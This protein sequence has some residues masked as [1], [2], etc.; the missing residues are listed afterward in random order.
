MIESLLIPKEDIT[1]IPESLNCRDALM[2]LE[3]TDQR[4]A[5]VVDASNS[6]F[7]GNIYKYHI[8][9]YAFHHPQEDLGQVSVTNLLKNSSRI[10]HIQD[11]LHTLL[12]T[13]RDL[14]YIP[15]LDQNHHFVGVVYHGDFTSYLSKA[16]EGQSPYVIRVE[17]SDIIRD[18]HRILKITHRY[19]TYSSLLTFK[20]TPLNPHPFVM[21]TLDKATDPIKIN[22]L[23][24]VLNRKGYLAKS[25]KT[26]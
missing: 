13:I 18:L 9:K 17:L 14:P 3:D 12:F 20:A 15:V 19:L 26:Y 1:T 5:P 10:V 23:V 24:S 22:T 16:W 2:I 7:R 8:Y 21:I 25:L 4:C 6:L 11:S